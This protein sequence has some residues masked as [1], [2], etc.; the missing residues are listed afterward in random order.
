MIKVGLDLSNWAKTANLK[1]VTIVDTSNLA[2]K[3]N[4]ASLKAEEDKIDIEKL[5]TVPA[6]LKRPVVDN[7]VVKKSA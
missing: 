6:D 7:D 5:K 4:I 1:R 2:V 3:S